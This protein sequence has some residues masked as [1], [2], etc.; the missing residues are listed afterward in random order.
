MITTI[1]KDACIG[2]GNCPV[3]CPEIYQMDDDGLAITLN[4]HVPEELEETAQEAAENC[5]TEAIIIN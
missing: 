2:C 1:E 3:I 4:E 5:P